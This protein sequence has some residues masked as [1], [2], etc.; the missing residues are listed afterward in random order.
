MPDLLLSAPELSDTGVSAVGTML[1]IAGIA[2]VLGLAAL[3]LAH[4]RKDHDGS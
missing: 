1:I 3:F 2:L 4:R